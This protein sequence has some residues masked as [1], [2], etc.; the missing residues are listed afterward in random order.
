M[1]RTS[2]LIAV[3]LM[4]NA[5][6][7]QTP[8]PACD[9]PETK[10]LDFWVGEWDLTYG[11]GGKGRNRVTKILDGC[12]ILEEFTGAPGT[13]LNGKSFSTFDRLTKQW[14]Q[15]WVDDTSTYLDLTGKFADGR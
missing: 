2:L 4:S 15:T 9:S 5:S 3:L 11:D 6:R 14:K 1:F 10:Q 12:V 7:A 13:K 8:A